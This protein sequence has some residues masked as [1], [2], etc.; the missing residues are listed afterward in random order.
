VVNRT[1][2]VIE[3]SEVDLNNTILDFV[4]LAKEVEDINV[5]FSREEGFVKRV[6][7]LSNQGI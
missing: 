7:V 2:R 5:D 6:F 1:E 3:V 4:L